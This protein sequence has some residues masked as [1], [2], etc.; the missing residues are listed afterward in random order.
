MAADASSRS[1]IRRL[2][3]NEDDL[4]EYDA[5]GP[6]IYEITDERDTSKRFRAACARQLDARLLLKLPRNVELRDVRPGMHLD[7]EVL[8]VNEHGVS[9]M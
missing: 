2:A 1:T 5:F 4:R 6:W 3:A 8:A 7:V 9:V